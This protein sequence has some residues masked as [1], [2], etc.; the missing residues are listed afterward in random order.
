VHP[1]DRNDTTGRRLFTLTNGADKPLV[2]L[3]LNAVFTDGAGQRRLCRTTIV[4]YDLAASASRD[5]G[6]FSDEEVDA[7]RDVE[8]TIQRVT[9]EDGSEWHRAA[10]AAARGADAAPL[11]VTSTDLVERQLDG[12]EERVFLVENRSAKPISAYDFTID[13]PPRVDKWPGAI[14]LRG[15]VQPGEALF[16]AESGPWR[17]QLSARTTVAIRGVVFADKT[18]WS[19]E[20]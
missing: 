2:D 12:R 9:Y 16:A 18:R 8:L 11:R 13:D 15:G 14:R 19:P 17:S 20:N 10:V 7:A 3:S 5:V 1:L 4:L 6:L